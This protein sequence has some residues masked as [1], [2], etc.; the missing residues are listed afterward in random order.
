LLSS[1]DATYEYDANGN[2]AKK[3]V[4]SQV[5]TYTYDIDNRLTGVEV[6]GSGAGT[7]TYV[8]DLFGRRLWKEVGGIKTHFLYTDE[9][10]VGEYDSTGY[11]IKTY[12][13]SPNST[14]STNPLFQKIGSDYYWY[15]NDHLGTPQKMTDSS[16]AVAWSATYD[17]FGNATVN[18]GS[19]ITNNLRFP[20]Q[21]YDAK[22]G[23]HYN[24]NRYYDPKTGRYI[25]ADP[26]GLE[27]G[28]NLFSY[29]LSNP[30]MLTD[31]RGLECDIE[32]CLVP[33]E[34]WGP[35]VPTWL[36]PTNHAFLKIDG[37][38]YGFTGGPGETKADAS[39]RREPRAADPRVNCYK[40]K[41]RKDKNCCQ[42]GCDEI[43]KCVK[44]KI[45]KDK[46]KGY[47][48]LTYNCE[49]A[50]S[51]SLT[52][53]CMEDANSTVPWYYAPSPFS[54]W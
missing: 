12:G 19:T 3:T 25:T 45:D 6:Q 49:T 24:W 31:S 11:E 29:V 27:G 13:Y 8:Y 5:T 48:F 46:R 22:T 35:W 30:I 42:W 23:Y 47:N 33:M 50:G 4:G 32:V 26:I 15:Q 52:S 7:A 51:E 44:D 36:A 14:W 53:C 18:A 39:I 17:A 38:S 43:K 21:Y 54:G 34:V 1:V 10:L 2:T 40:A 9:G 37:R 28:G 41:K 20:G 16:G